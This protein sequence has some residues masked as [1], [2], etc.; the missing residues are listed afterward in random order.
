[1][2]VCLY[3]K[4]MVNR[5]LIFICVYAYNIRG[6]INLSY[7]F[8]NHIRERLSP[9]CFRPERIVL[10]YHSACENRNVFFSFKKRHSLNLIL[11]FD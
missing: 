9:L 2:P 5:N 4:C 3:N 11:Q 8:I 7:L 6:N 1:M 10:T